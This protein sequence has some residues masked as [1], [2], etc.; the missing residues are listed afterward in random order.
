MD[1]NQSCENMRKCLNSLSLLAG[2]ERISMERMVICT[3]RQYGRGGRKTDKMRQRYFDTYS[4]AGWGKT[5]SYDLLLSGS[6]FGIE[7]CTDLIMAAVS[8]TRGGISYE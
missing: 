4:G 1:V 8:V 6:R 2:M 3:G 5:E 7:K